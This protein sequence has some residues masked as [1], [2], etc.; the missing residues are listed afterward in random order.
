VGIIDILEISKLV[1]VLG[2]VAKISCGNVDGGQNCEI[3]LE[4]SVLAVSYSCHV[5]MH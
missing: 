4:I 5:L 1:N 3:W 2:V